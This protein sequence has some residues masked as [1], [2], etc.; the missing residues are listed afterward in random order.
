MSIASLSIDVA[1]Y[2][3]VQGTISVRFDRWD[4]SRVQFAYSITAAGEVLAE[5]DDLYSGTTERVDLVDGMRSLLSFLTAAAESYASAGMDGENSRLF[6]EKCVQWAD[7][8]SDEL[9]TA[10]Y[11]LGD[12]D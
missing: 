5:G 1:A 2:G 3:V 11:E 10:A 6:P 4:G 12:M 7:A 8:L 9:S